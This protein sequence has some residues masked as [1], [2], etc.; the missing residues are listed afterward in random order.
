MK[1]SLLSSNHHLPDRRKETG[2]RREVE[3]WTGYNFDGRNNKYS[4][5]KYH[6]YHFTGTD[7]EAR[8]KSSEHIYRFVGE[9]KPGWAR[10][11][12]DELGNYDF[13]YEAT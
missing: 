9:N 2:K 11:V 8:L 1:A 10:D 7:F 5:F 6:W 13:L 4:S 3:V 12:D